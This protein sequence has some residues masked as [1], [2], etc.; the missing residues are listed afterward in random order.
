MN[1]ILSKINKYEYCDIN[2]CCWVTAM[3]Q[4]IIQEP[5]LSNSS[6]NSI[7]FGNKQNQQLEMVHIR[8]DLRL[9][10]KGKQVILEF[11]LWRWVTIL[12]L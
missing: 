11:P 5:L 9:Y 6:V 7:F 8:S 3:E 1:L 10:Q 2:T 12:P 4:T